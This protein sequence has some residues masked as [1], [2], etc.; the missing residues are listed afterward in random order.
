MTTTDIGREMISR[1]RRKRA[2]Q[3]AKYLHENGF[4]HVDA[5]N[6]TEGQWQTAAS[7]AGLKSAPSHVT[8]GIT[9]GY[10]TPNEHDPLSPV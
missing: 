10:L 2:G 3:L 4:N 5:S 6:F 8:Q 7:V 1:N 9:I